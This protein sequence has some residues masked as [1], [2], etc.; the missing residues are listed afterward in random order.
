M[1]QSPRAPEASVKIHDSQDSY[2][3]FFEKTPCV[4]HKDGES[5]IEFLGIGRRYDS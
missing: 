2:D 4:P 3:D 1:I 5:Y